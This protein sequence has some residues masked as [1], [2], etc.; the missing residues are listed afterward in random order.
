VA[1]CGAAILRCA[2]TAP[3]SEEDGEQ[4]TKSPP[5]QRR[6]LGVVLSLAPR[7]FDKLSPNGSCSRILQRSPFVLSL[8]KDASAAPDH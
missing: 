7:G 2:S 5:L 3:S 4:D 8:S 1:M 6:G